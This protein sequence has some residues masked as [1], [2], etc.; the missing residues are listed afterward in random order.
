MVVSTTPGRHTQGLTPIPRP[1]RRAVKEVVKGEEIP[2]IEYHPPEETG[3]SAATLKPIVQLNTANVLPS[4]LLFEYLWHTSYFLHNPCPSWSGY[5]SDVSAALSH[6]GKA[7]I[8]ML[9]IIDLNPNDMNCI[10]F[11]LCFIESQAGY[12]E[13]VTPVV[14]YDQHYG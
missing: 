4:D 5:M 1:K 10:Y 14:T 9:P 8:S 12:L 13:I 6:P 7:A 3:L 2:I 11:T